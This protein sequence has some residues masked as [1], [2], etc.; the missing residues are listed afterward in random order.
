M[1]K[2][3]R[4]DKNRIVAMIENS[5]IDENEIVCIKYEGNKKQQGY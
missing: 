4:V 5:A 3:H 1:K 2:L